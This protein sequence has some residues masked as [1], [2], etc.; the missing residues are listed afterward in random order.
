LV[1]PVVLWCADGWLGLGLW[2][3]LGL[4]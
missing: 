4:S 3:A 2:L 1:S